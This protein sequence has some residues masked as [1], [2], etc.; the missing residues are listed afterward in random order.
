M[1]DIEKGSMSPEDLYKSIYNL[2]SSESSDND[3]ITNVHS[4]EETGYDDALYNVAFDYDNDI[5]VVIYI[6]DN[7]KI[8]IDCPEDMIA[9]TESLI[10]GEFPELMDSFE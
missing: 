8:H 7:G 2:I 10:T 3:L 9:G 5:R 4:V 1:I 6:L